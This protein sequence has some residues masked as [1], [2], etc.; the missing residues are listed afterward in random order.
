MFS[1]RE[2][3]FG[4]VLP[5]VCVLV[6]F[7]F[8]SIPIFNVRESVK[9]VQYYCGRFDFK[10]IVD[11]DMMHFC[12]KVC[13]MNNNLCNIVLV[14]VYKMNN[15]LCNIVL[16]IFKEVISSNVCVMIIVLLYIV[17]CYSLYAL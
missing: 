2:F 5:K 4:S 15:D 9:E 3:S 8:G 17:V 10:H 11:K 12:S 16:V 14:K 7:G 6:R 1:P 13:K